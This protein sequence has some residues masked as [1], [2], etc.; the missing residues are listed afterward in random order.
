[1]AEDGNSLK[2]G[3]T[4]FASG[5]PA[6][7][8]F[9]QRPLARAATLGD[10]SSPS[11]RRR[12]SFMTSDSVDRQS[13]RSSMNEILLPRPLAAGQNTQH[14]PSHLHSA[15][16]FLALLPAVGGV[17]FNNGGHI[18]TDL[19]LLILGA[20]F[21]NWSIRLPWDWYYSA[22]SVRTEPEA[23]SEGY[24]PTEDTII[25]EQSEGEEEDPS[26]REI[27]KPAISRRSSSRQLKNTSEDSSERSPA[28]AAAS[29]E[30]R[31][32][33]L[34]ALFF[35]FLGPLLGAWLL[36]AIR[37]QLS[38]PSEG[39]V[40]NYNLCIFILAAEMRPT[41][42]VLTLIQSRTLYL[43]RVVGTNPHLPS[44]PESTTLKEIQTRLD[45]V[46][47]HIARSVTE[48]SVKANGPSSTQVAVEVRKGVQS[49]LDALNRAMRRYE[50]R[51]IALE[52]ATK[53]EL[54][55][56]DQ[57]I[58]DA[59]ALSAAVA[60]N[61]KSSFT[62]VL[63]FISTLFLVP[64]QAATAVVSAILGAPKVVIDS[65]LSVLEPYLGKMLGWFGPKRT[66]R[67]EKEKVKEG[68]EGSRRKRRE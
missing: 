4:A 37:S 35:C 19:T 41:S 42:H 20:V 23:F 46:E 38:R 56:H 50:K 61:K 48:A 25:E 33:E 34:I 24:L 27:T 10:I 68:A 53:A 5:R 40:S 22:Q 49:E 67:K 43:Q 6:L 12:S 60:R 11:E 64:A 47:A 65:L 62:V 39:L 13:M 59:L 1:M 63:D 18:L 36:H 2:S 30:L 44:V 16:L 17:L 14:E 58:K 28:Q 57:R 9:R 15:P 66:K 54:L 7:S 8:P 31:S 52:M 29:S 55:D 3:S 45:E 51:S 21:L 32:H 26:R